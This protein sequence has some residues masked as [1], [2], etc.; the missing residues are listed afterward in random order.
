MTRPEKSSRPDA[1]RPVVLCI[2]DGWGE[3]AETDNNAIAAARTPVFDR[4]KATGPFA[5]LDASEGFVGLPS[6]QMGNSEVG[7]M[8]LGAGRVVMQELPKIDAAI[9]DGSLAAHSRLAAFAAALKKTGGTAHLMGLLSD[10]G[11]H[12]HLRHMAA[13]ANRLVELGVPVAVHGF[14]DGRDTP[15]RSADGFVADFEAA[16]PK[17]PIATL[18]GRYWA[19]DRDKRWD[20]VKK[21]YD[22]LV[23]GTGAAI[24]SASEAVAASYSADIGDEFVEPAAINGYAGMKDGDGLLMANFRADRAREILSA[25]LDP[26]FD[27][28]DRARRVSFADALGMVEYSQA[29]KAFLDSIFP[30]EDLVDVLGAVV[31]DAGLKQLR[32]AETEKYAHVTFFL[33]GGRE[34]VFDGE[35]RILVQSPDVKTYDLQPEMSAPEVTDKLV[36]AIEAGTYDLI[37]VNYANTDMVGHTGDFD[38]AV[39]AVQAVDGCLGRLEQAL[40]KAGGR[41]LITADHGNADMMVDP[42][43]GGIHTAHTLSKVPLILVGAQAGE[44]EGL[45]NGRLADIAPTLL[46]LMKLPQ[47]A[48]MTGHSLLRRAARHAA[49]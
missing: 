11:V 16:A 34:D 40:T 42:S 41:M 36:A 26:G 37:V 35:D 31:A 33:N 28:F 21:A 38:A 6:G 18:C 19:M 14:L 46:E 5:V 49:E 20:R 48:A 32:I 15:P 23:D 25:L 12:S 10:G 43:S 2:L 4:L 29:H 47:P 17:A 7:H 24:E 22:L 13:L 39:Q 30:P 27:G 44:V 45:G 3:R 9:E 1:P 8:N